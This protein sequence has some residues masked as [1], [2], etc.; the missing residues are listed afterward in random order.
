MTATILTAEAVRKVY[1]SCVHQDGEPTIQMLPVQSVRDAENFHRERVEQ[2]RGEILALLAQLPSAFRESTGE[3]STQACL[4]RY[5][6]QW[7][8]LEYQVGWLIAMGVA[9]GAAEILGE[10]SSWPQ[11]HTDPRV[12]ICL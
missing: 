11:N 5:G 9:V 8:R 6:V 2:A 7:T 4:D 3:R 12:R 1:V 10:T